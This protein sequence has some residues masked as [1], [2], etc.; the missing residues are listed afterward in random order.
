MGG[1]HTED[2]PERDGR[3][4]AV[5]EAMAAHE[6]FNWSCQCHAWTFHPPTVNYSGEDVRA[7]HRA[8]VA[9]AILAALSATPADTGADAVVRAL[10]E[11]ERRIIHAIETLDPRGSLI[12]VREVRA[13]VR[14][15]SSADTEAGL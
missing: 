5:S 13:E 10:D 1:D 7:A 11:V 3:V 2:R 12:H 8:H 4:G 14:A 15:Q 6:R 9:A